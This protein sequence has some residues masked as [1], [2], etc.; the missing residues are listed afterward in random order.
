[1]QKRSFVGDFVDFNGSDPNRHSGWHLEKRF[2]TTPRLARTISEY[3]EK[4]SED[5]SVKRICPTGDIT[6]FSYC[7]QQEFAS[8]P[9]NANSQFLAGTAN[10]LLEGC[11][12]LTIVSARA[13]YMVNSCPLRLYAVS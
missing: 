3:L 10:T 6:G 4:Q 9:L 11:T 5:A 12:V 7:F 13:V 2:L 1:M 8:A